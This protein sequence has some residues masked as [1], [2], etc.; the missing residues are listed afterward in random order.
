MVGLP[1]DLEFSEE[2]EQ[3][4]IDIRNLLLGVHNG[5]LSLPATRERSLAKTKL[6]ECYF[7]AL[8]AVAAM[9]VEDGEAS[10]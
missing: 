5:L 1:D 7:W 2:Q 9:E 4:W 10:E 6:D 3:T 8:G